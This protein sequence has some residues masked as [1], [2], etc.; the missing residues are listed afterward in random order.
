MAA[1]TVTAPRLDVGF[2]RESAVAS[3]FCIR[4]AGICLLGGGCA[5][6]Y[7]SDVTAAPA[8]KSAADQSVP[9]NFQI[10]DKA[11][12]GPYALGEKISMLDLYVWMFGQWVDQGPL[13][14]LCPNVMALRATVAARPEI[15]AVQARNPS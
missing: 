4:S 7:T 13:S 14:E 12:V 6:R 2:H 9:R 1:D 11:I 15:A 5:D 3:S 8:V 10:F